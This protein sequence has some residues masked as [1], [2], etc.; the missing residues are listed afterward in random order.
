MSLPLWFRPLPLPLL[1]I[2]TTFLGYTLHAQVTV[3]P[4]RTVDLDRPAEEILGERLFLE[5]RFAHFFAVNSGGNLNQE[6]LANGGDP[7]LTVIQTPTGPVP[8]PFRGKT[9]NCAQCHLS[10]QLL[11]RNGVAQFNDYQARTPV[12]AREDG[13]LTTPR[14]T[15]SIRNVGRVFESALQVFYH[16]DAEFTTL[17]GLVEDTLTG[18]NYGWL[19]AEQT[20]ATQHIAQ[21]IRQDD[22]S[23]ALAQAYGG[24][25]RQVLT[26]NSGN[27]IVA[28]AGYCLTNFDRAKEDEILGVIGK[29]VRQY[30]NSLET[31]RDETGAY[32]GTAYD[33]FLKNNGLP[34]LPNGGETDR[35]YSQRLLVALEQLTA[36]QWV[37]ANDME[38]E[39]NRYPY[40]F[41]PKE[42]Q[43]L[44]IF[45]RSPSGSTPTTEELSSGG[46]G[47]CLA[48]HAAPVFTDF[49][50]HNTGVNQ[51]EYDQLHGNGA[52]AQLPVPDLTTRNANYDLYLPATF[53]H[54]NAE[55][56]FR[57]PAKLEDPRLTDLGL[58]N[59]F[60][61]PDFLSVDPLSIKLVLGGNLA[62]PDEEF[63]PVT[64][65]RFKTPGLRDITSGN[66][67]FHNG[68]QPT[69][70]GVVNFYRQTSEAA[71]Q[72]QI[73]NGDLELARI[74]LVEADQKALV[75]FLRS[76]KEDQR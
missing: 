42:F 29:L 47:N 21:V 48:C 10:D 60:A 43:G 64:L 41:G 68:S 2:A 15:A 57:A 70:K 69:L 34:R 35:A 30:L 46:K 55:E 63:L 58:W 11:P 40:R 5:T 14:N 65:G 51:Q 62:T 8:G 3:P 59:M 36:P 49:S 13:V 18:R 61:N 75:A 9:M 73:R 54:P 22:G 28:P 37:S 4:I 33:V 20:L 38:F 50:F 19:P 26:C 52:F 16:G 39:N 44:K 67:Y 12:P 74:A 32:S 6:P 1:V 76:L 56:V 24:S 31:Q 45:L 53:K 66:P 7:T 72:G 27:G 25:Y 71:R 17:N 23:G